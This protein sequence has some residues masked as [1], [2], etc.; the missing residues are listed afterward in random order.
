MA[1][2]VRPDAVAD[3]RVRA[4]WLAVAV[5]AL[6]LILTADDR[7]PGAIAD[8]RQMAWTAVAITETGGIGQARGRDFTWP[9]SGGDAVSRYGMGMSLAQVPA[10]WLAPKIEARLGP[11]TS[12]PL[13][14]LVPLLCVCIAAAA[15]GWIALSLG[16][17][18][19]AARAAVLLTA[20][21]S[22]LGAYAALDL[23]EP[24]Q[25]AAL[26][27][28]LALSLASADPQVQRRRA[29]IYSAMAGLA[30]G[31]AV[32][33]KSGL[34]AVVPFS[35]L[36]VWSPNG[37]VSRPRRVMATLAGF[38]G[39]VAV[40]VWFD[41]ARFGEL[42]ASY[43]GE[44]FTHPF[45]DGFWRLLLGVNRGLVLYFPALVVALA[46]V[47]VR[48]RSAH[49]RARLAMLSSL[50]AFVALL[51]LAAAWW[52][53]HGLWG[54][55]P[56]LLVPAL[57]ALAALAAML[58]DR[59]PRP[60]R[61]AFVVVSV[62]INALGLVQNAGPVTMFTASCEWPAADASFAKSVAAYARRRGPDGTFHVAP[63]QV[64]ETVPGASPFVVYPW[65]AAST[66]TQ[67]SETAARRLQS[68][69]W[70]RA[71][72]DIRCGQDLSRD[73]VRRLIR[74]PGWSVWGRGFVT[75]TSAPGFPGV[76]DEG[77]L[78]QVVRAQQ[79]R[80]GEQALTLARKLASLAPSGEA[81]AQ[82]LES[83]R[84]LGRRSEAAEY[85]SSVPRE[86]RLEPKI[87][88]VLALFERDAGN[89]QTARS[90][91][92]SVAPSFGGSPAEEALS[93]PLAQW[94]PDLHSM[95]TSATDQ[96]G[97]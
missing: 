19:A 86:R 89:E 16:L 1:R 26:T 70:T 79:R 28:A 23:S 81:D 32:L 90:L 60:I 2:T 14:L 53:W 73:F 42:F 13:F 15:A 74:R 68:P 75:S 51:C 46:A 20:L 72:P 33:T 4:I 17:S 65:F 45:V 62:L 84:L 78:D 8:G 36:C 35:L 11:G 48:W 95:I 39:P 56:R 55:G 43:A 3:R 34:W 37:P 91:L 94:P 31:V 49:V 24:L 61:V 7:Y 83:L 18:A 92:A 97:R 25:A 50:G 21:G 96:A 29:L 54:W 80:R 6:A 47:A 9:R 12:Q 41:F 22:P 30:A 76:Y 69:P 44:G 71:R 57:P 59:W 5:S 52:A 93:A 64:L 27:S 38:A 63:D 85:L 82:V 66:W 87:N 88:L 77:L 58:L 67:D 40:W 10:A